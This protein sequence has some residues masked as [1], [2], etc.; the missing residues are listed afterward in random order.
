MITTGKI[1]GVGVA[2]GAVAGLVAITPAAG[3][4]GGLASI[5]FGLVA[6]IGCYFLIG[7]KNKLGYDD[8]LDVVGVHGGGGII[9]GLLLGL[10]ADNSA[11][12][13]EPGGFQDGVFFG[14]G[15]LFIDQVFAM[16]SVIA[17]SFVLTFVIAR[18]IDATV[19]LRVSEEDEVAGLDQSQHSETAYN[20]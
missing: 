13:A 8:S 6:G 12:N 5:V 15:E 4:V 9:G 18:A 7:L 16:A 14:G 19:G 10:F 11:F 20:L 3:Y 2:T 1:S 17:F